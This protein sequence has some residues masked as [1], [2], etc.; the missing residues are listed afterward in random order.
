MNAPLIPIFPSMDAEQLHHIAY[1]W[2][3]DDNCDDGYVTLHLIVEHPNCA[4]GTALLLYWRGEPLYF[5]QYATRDEV[6]GYH[7]DTY[8]FLA[9]LEQMVQTNKFQ[10]RGIVYD[11]RNDCGGVDLTIYKHNKRNGKFVLKRAIPLHMCIAT[12][13]DGIEQFQ[14][15]Q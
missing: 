7:Y 12:T 11:P 15:E 13:P 5:R 9:E 4:L 1:K 8:D 3:W 6:P 14:L 2:N 10:H